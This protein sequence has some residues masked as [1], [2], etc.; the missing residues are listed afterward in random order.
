MPEHCFCVFEFK[1]EFEFICLKFFF[2]IVKLFFFPSS[3]PSLLARFC[4]QALNVH[5]GP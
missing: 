3:L 2:K 1:F 4:F 5:L